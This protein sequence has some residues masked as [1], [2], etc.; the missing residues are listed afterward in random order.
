[1][2]IDIRSEEIFSLT[3]AT[4]LPC[5]RNRRAGKRINVSTLWRWATTGVRGVKLET[6]MAGGT[7]ATSLEAI[8]RFFEELTLQADGGQ[9]PAPQPPSLTAARRKEIEAAEQRLTKAGI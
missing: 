9:V 1:M 6:I 5:F 7:R 4:K 2:P 8:E 3:A